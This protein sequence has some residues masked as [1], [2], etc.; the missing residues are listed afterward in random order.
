[1]VDLSITIASRLATYSKGK[2]DNQK[3]LKINL[4]TEAR[5]ISL[6][7]LSLLF[8][9][10]IIIKGETIDHIYISKAELKVLCMHRGN[11]TP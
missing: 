10:I 7:Q 8:R 1:M 3:L 4:K 5:L 9:K 6:C 2:G 11:E